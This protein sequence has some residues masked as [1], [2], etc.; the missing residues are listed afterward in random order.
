MI[1]NVLVDLI[2]FCKASLQAVVIL[3]QSRRST[4][5]QTVI[6]VKLEVSQLPFCFKSHFMNWFIAFIHA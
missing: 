3:L 6:N 2:I 5:S 4:Q 1:F